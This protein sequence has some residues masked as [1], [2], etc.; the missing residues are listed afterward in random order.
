[1]YQAQS[2]YSVILRGAFS[3]YEMRIMLKIVQ[4]ARLLM[5]RQGRYSDFLNHA[6]SVDGFNIVFSIPVAELVGGHTHNYECI[7]AAARHMEKEWQVEYY[8]KQSRKW[9][10]TSMI[11]NVQLDERSGVL[12]FSAAD[13]LVRYIC[14]F[15]N[16]GYREYDFETAMSMR[17]PYAARMYLLTCSQTSPRVFSIDSLKEIMGVKDKYPRPNDFIRRCVE[18]ARAE[19]EKRGAN[20]FTYKVIRQYPDKQRSRPVSLQIVP[21]KREKKSANLSVQVADL[22]QQ[23]SPILTQYMSS[24][25]HFTYKEMVSNTKTL[26]AFCQVPMWQQLFTDIVDRARRKNKGHGYIIAAMKSTVKEKG[27]ATDVDGGKTQS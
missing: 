17:S 26:T 20:G 1:M 24:Q 23:V 7:K 27:A 3:V 22:K 5:K 21:V 25:L 19:L 8:D 16:G 11:Y 4:R 10:L 18:P 6:Y 12:I 13:W 9:Y 2:Y 15:R 14:D